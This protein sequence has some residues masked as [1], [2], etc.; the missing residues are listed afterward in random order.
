MIV[1]LLKRNVSCYL[2]CLDPE[3]GL[4]VIIVDQ[5]PRG[6]PKLAYLQSSNGS[7]SVLRKFQ[8]LSTRILLQKEV[9]I[10]ELEKLLM[11]QDIA[12]EKSDLEERQSRLRTAKYFKRTPTKDPGGVDNMAQPELTQV[13]CENLKEY[14]EYPAL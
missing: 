4:T 12:D 5:F 2:N 3:Y 11:E 6:F 13:I 8:Y 10:N 14:S 7:F 1:E 9:E